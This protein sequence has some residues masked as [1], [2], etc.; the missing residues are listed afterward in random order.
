M[1]DDPLHDLMEE[2]A[3]A[4]HALL[5]WEE[6]GLSGDLLTDLAEQ[7]ARQAD[8]LWHLHNGGE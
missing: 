4:H 2:Q 5:A 7:S 8:A 3:A 6:Q 1:S